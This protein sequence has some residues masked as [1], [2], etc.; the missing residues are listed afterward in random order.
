MAR[1]DLIVLLLLSVITMST[2]TIDVI[3]WNVT[4]VM[5]SSSY[6]CDVITEGKLT[7]VAFQNIGFIH[8]ICSS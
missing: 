8:T 4:G 6:L 5:S 7:F 3:T 2:N 1:R